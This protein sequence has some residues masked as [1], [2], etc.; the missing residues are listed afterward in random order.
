MSMTNG[1]TL[2]PTANATTLP[3]TNCKMILIQFW[4]LRL[5]YFVHNHKTTCQLVTPQDMQRSNDLLIAMMIN[6]KSLTLMEAPALS[7]VPMMH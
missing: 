7:M 1:K 3:P 5:L 4:G 2:L 6:L